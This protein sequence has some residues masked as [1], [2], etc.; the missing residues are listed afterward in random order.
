MC[1]ISGNRL[2]LMAG[3]A[4]NILLVKKFMKIPREIWSYQELHSSG[5]NPQLWSPRNL[6]GQQPR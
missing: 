3:R 2:I 1:N 6:F 5:S 4:G